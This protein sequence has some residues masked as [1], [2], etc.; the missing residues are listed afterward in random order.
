[1]GAE[2]ASR[3]NSTARQFLA[4]ALLLAAIVALFVA[5]ESGHRQLA[6]ASQRFEQAARRTGAIGSMLQIL[7][8]AE[9]AQRGY[10]LLGNAAYLLPYTA[11][12]NKV[13]SELR[14]LQAAFASADS[15]TRADIETI[16][17]LTQSKVME[18][19]D[20]LDLYRNQGRAAATSLVRTDVGQRLMADIGERAGKIQVAETHEMLETSRSWHSNR[21][22]YLSLTGGAAAACV[23][24]VLLL[25][26]LVA[27]HMYSKEREAEELAGRQAELERIVKNRTEELSG[28]STQLQSATEKARSQLS[29]ELHDELG[30]LL[31][32]ARM[33]AS[34]LE[35][36]TATGNPSLK[37]R[38]K[39]LQDALQ[40]GIELKRRVVEDLRPTLLDN[41]GLLPALQWQVAESC[42]RAGLKCIE[43]YPS[44]ELTLTPEASIAIFRIVQEAL[45]NI[46]KHAKARN[47][48]VCVAVAEESLLITVRDDGVGLPV[49]QRLALRSHG[50]ASMRHRATALDGQL[51]ISSRIQ[52]G[53]EIEARLPLRRVVAAAA[54]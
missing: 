23:F 15:S 35:D 18:M 5:A 46:L 14:E 13:P 2:I 1:M 47:V 54:A 29:R 4:V 9:S 37:A 43:R 39:R 40:A 12:T 27:R 22:L 26:G 21:W 38:F 53:T 51:R 52:G 31:T 20:S 33:D 32:A 7:S 19:N 17:Q 30:G 45:T 34:W 44:E 49:D 16:V 6:E 36:K 10:I 41:L 8:Q 28:L 11:A 25:R 24:L 3:M 42:A 48:E 50:M